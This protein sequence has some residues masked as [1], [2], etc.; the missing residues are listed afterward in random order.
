MITLGYSDADSALVKT[1]RTRF[2]YDANNRPRFTVDA[3]GSVSE[4]VYD[5]A[6]QPVSSVRYAT[7]PLL[8]ATTESAIDA[9]LNR[10]NTSNQISHY[11]YDAAGGLRYSVR[12]LASDTTGK[13]TQHLVSEQ[14]YDPLGR[15]VQTIAYATLIGSL[16]DYTAATLATAITAGTQDRRSAFVYDAAG[17]KVYGVQVQIGGSQYIV[18]KRAFDALDRLVETTSYAK[19]MALAD[20]GKATLDSVTTANAS[21]QDRTT[22]LIYDAAGRKRF[23]VGADGSLS[24]TVYDAAGRISE[25][26]RFDVLLSDTTARTE[27]ALSAWR[28]GRAVGDGIT[29]VRSTA[30]IGSAGS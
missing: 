20:F 18:G 17:R 24:E 8:T 30:T 4:S 5:P 12:V 25:S 3:L 6:G 2:A 14:V 22:R 19:T 29:P 15:V 9:A 21:A 11:V 1:Q 10:A 16:V 27:D 28:A 13:P 26:R 23:A 7:R